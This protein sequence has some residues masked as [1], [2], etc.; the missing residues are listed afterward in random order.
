MWVWMYVVLMMW[1][2]YVFIIVCFE[3]LLV[4]VEIKVIVGGM[5]MV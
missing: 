3:E 2:V 4:Y 5:M 1:L